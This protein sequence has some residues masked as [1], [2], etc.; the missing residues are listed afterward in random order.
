METVFTVLLGAV[1]KPFTLKYEKGV[2][3]QFARL[4]SMIRVCHL[5][6]VHEYNDVRIM[7][8]ECISLTKAG[9]DVFLVACGKSTIIDDVKI[10]G[11]GERPKSRIARFLILGREY[12]KSHQYR[13]RYLSYS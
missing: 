9:Y 2:S 4:G 10:V 12:L 1:R 5:T 8:K 6:S 13:C 7:K 11:V 3:W